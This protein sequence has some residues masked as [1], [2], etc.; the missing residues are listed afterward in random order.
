MN[1]FYLALIPALW[2]AWLL[3]W[4]FAAV[5]A[6]ETQRQESAWSRASHIVPLIGKR[7]WPDGFVV[8]AG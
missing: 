4:I 7:H 2:I 1:Y 5:G 6:K 8:P 3:Y